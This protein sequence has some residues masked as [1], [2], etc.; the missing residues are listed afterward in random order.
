MTIKYEMLM[1]ALV[2][3]ENG[4]MSQ[5]IIIMVLMDSL[6]LFICPVIMAQ[7]LYTPQFDPNSV[8]GCEGY[9]AICG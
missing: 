8:G 9:Q 4:C 2:N 1:K 6:L 3:V 7:V 5:M